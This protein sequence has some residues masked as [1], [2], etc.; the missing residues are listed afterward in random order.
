MRFTWSPDGTLSI[1]ILVYPEKELHEDVRLLSNSEVWGQSTVRCDKV[2]HRALAVYS[3]L[4]Y[5][6]CTC[7]EGPSPIWHQTY[8]D[9]STAL[10][11][12]PKIQPLCL[13][14]NAYMETLNLSVPKSSATVFTTFSNEVSTVLWVATEVLHKSST[15]YRKHPQKYRTIPYIFREKNTVHT[16]KKSSCSCTVYTKK[17]LICFKKAPNREA[18]KKV[19]LWLTG[20]NWQCCGAG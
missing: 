8:A 14:L 9:D 19:L 7:P 1:K 18:A 16:Q 17:K 5:L 10:C 6:I 15:P 13:K 3:L 20:P 12:G 2:C 4:N 11:S